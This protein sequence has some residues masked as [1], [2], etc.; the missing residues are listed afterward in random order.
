[1]RYV[2]SLVL[3]L[4]AAGPVLTQV[5]GAPGDS[6]ATRLTLEYPDTIPL[7]DD[8]PADTVP[9]VGFFKKVLSPVYPN[10]ERAALMS[11]VVPGA[12]QIYNRRLWWLKV[13]AIYAG[14]ALFVYRGVENRREFNRTQEAYLLALEEGS[15]TATRLRTSRDNFSKNYQLSFIGLA[16]LHLV[17]TLEAFTTAHLL[18]FDMDESLTLRPVMLPGLDG[19]GGAG[20]LGLSL[21]VGFGG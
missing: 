4:A 19:L 17:Q 7:I 6:S 18:D 12:G 11:F 21:T 1:M 5:V 15:P 13:P 2:L 14:S 3:L 16:I 8:T 9:K 10:P 20:T